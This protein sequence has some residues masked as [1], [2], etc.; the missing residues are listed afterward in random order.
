MAVQIGM[1]RMKFYNN[2]HKLFEIAGKITR[3]QHRRAIDESG[4]TESGST[5]YDWETI[6]ANPCFTGKD[7]NGDPTYDSD[8]EEEGF[9][10]EEV[11]LAPDTGGNSRY[12]SPNTLNREQDILLMSIQTGYS[13]R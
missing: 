2:Q 6:E 10:E 3:A 8:C 5:E 13:K 9:M 7:A 12:G 11:Q 1:K 4:S